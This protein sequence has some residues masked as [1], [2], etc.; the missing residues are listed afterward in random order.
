[1]N[2]EVPFDSVESAHEFVTIL[3][4]VVVETKRD[5]DV[6]IQLE[7]SSSKFPRR[8]KALQ[9]VENKMR[10]LESHL[11]KIRRIFNDLRSLRRLLFGERTTPSTSPP[12][13]VSRSGVPPESTVARPASIRATVRKRTLSSWRD[14]HARNPGV[15]GAGPWYVRRDRKPVEGITT[16]KAA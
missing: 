2:P 3:A 7:I 13:E 12:S 11:E 14:A 5:I 10:A 4:Q 16:A 8:L 6:D 15:A 9:I 1:M